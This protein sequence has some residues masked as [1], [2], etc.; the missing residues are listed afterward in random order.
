MEGDGEG[1]R[2]R[3]LLFAARPQ[4]RRV[5]NNLPSGGAA[6]SVI[7]LVLARLIFAGASEKRIQLFL[8]R[9]RADVEFSVWHK[10]T[11]YHSCTG[12]AVEQPDDE[13]A[14]DLHAAQPPESPGS[15]VTLKRDLLSRLHARLPFRL[16]PFLT[17]SAETWKHVIFSYSRTFRQF[18]LL[19]LSVQKTPSRRRRQLLQLCSTSFHL[20]LSLDAALTA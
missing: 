17:L 7:R 3:P 10:W 16:L 20:T 13:A 14:L 4:G 15:E 5:S 8:E 9:D 12:E 18:Q 1:E 19:S 11:T 2:S 6:L